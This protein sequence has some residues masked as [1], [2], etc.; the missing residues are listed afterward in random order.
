M[1]TFRNLEQLHMNDCSLKSLSNLPEGAKLVRLELGTNQITGA[2]LK[3]LNKYAGT[4]RTLKL[5][6]NQLKSYADL[7]S[8]AEL[9]VL[10]N[11]DLEKN[12]VTKLSDYKQ[13]M[14]R[15]LPS[16]Q[17]LDNQNRAG[18]LVFSDDDDFEDDE[19]FEGGEDEYD[20]MPE[21]LNEEKL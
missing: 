20:E 15:L 6:A 16:L 13:H 1:S 17:V 19:G 4:L 3:H 12:A 7:E 21:E 8:L 10:K 11:L 9:K 5:A 14:F 2:E 18:E